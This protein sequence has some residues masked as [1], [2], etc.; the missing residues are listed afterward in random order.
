MNL[1]AKWPEGNEAAH[2]GDLAADIA[3]A[4]AGGMNV[5]DRLAFCQL[6]GMDVG[7]SRRLL[8]I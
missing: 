1:P 4:D 3:M 6:Y 8:G 2:G 5:N 7:E